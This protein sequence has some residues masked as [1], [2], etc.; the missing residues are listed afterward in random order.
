[1]P[2]EIKDVKYPTEKELN[3]R[4]IELLNYY[5]KPELPFSFPGLENSSQVQEK[6][7]KPF[8]QKLLKSY[9]MPFDTL[10]AA[11]YGS[12]FMEEM[13]RTEK[14]VSEIVRPKAYTDLLALAVGFGLMI[15]P[16]ENSYILSLKKYVSKKSN[17]IES[18]KT[19]KGINALAYLIF[20]TTMSLGYKKLKP[21]TTKG[22]EEL[23]HY[24]KLFRDEKI[25]RNFIKQFLNARIPINGRDIK[26]VSNHQGYV[27]IRDPNVDG[28]DKSLYIKEIT[29]ILS[30]IYLTSS[31]PK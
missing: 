27:E 31:V 11:F 25:S 15:E 17:E 14:C 3:K 29:N 7:N 30:K 5:Q 21:K 12:H 10:K 16:V 4:F 20:N 28:K 26:Y 2:V 18:D 24:K 19:E 13:E 6:R 22:K 1:M 9:D 23:G 8:T